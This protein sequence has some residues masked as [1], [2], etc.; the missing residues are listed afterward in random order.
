MYV[1]ILRRLS[2]PANS[3]RIYSFLDKFDKAIYFGH[4]ILNPILMLYAAMSILALAFTCIASMCIPSD[5]VP[6]LGYYYVMTHY[7][8]IMLRFLQTNWLDY[9]CLYPKW[10]RPTLSQGFLLQLTYVASR[11]FYYILLSFGVT[12]AWKR[13]FPNKP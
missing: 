13:L 6:H 1:R 5:C 9:I 2:Y 11:A 7:P 4:S 3:S 8:T 10:V 12:P